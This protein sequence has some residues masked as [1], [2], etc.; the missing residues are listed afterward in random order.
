MSTDI[1]NAATS[2]PFSSSAAV[3]TTVNAVKGTA[4]IVTNI[5][6]VADML[7]MGAGLVLVAG[8]FIMAM[9]NNNTLK[10]NVLKILP[11]VAE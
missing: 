6:P 10:N 8:A 5:P 3:N 4:A 1:K 11:E 2:N 9:G 7:I